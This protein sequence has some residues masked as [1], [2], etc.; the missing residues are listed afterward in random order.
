MAHNIR[1]LNDPTKQYMWINYCKEEEYDI[2]GTIETKL[3]PDK[4]K[5]IY[6]KD[7][8]YKAYWS[9]NITPKGGVGILISD[10]NATPNPKEDR[11]GKRN[12][13]I[14][15]SYLLKEMVKSNW[16]DVMRYFH[17]EEEKYTW[18]NNENASRIDQVWMESNSM[19]L[20]HTYIQQDAGL[21]TTS[22]H[23]I[24]G[25]K[26][27]NL[28]KNNNCGKNTISNHQRSI[29]NFKTTTSKEWENYQIN[30][31]EQLKNSQLSTD[32]LKITQD[33]KQKTNILES[34]WQR[35]S[36]C[37]W[38]AAKQTLPNKK[39]KSKKI[40]KE[41]QGKE[42]IIAYKQMQLIRKLIARV[43]RRDI[44]NNL[45]PQDINF[46]NYIKK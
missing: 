18:R 25:C 42:E 7:D 3:T 9:S 46:I 14:P 11:K 38:K 29:F 5:Y 37:I 33:N 12:S 36:E 28:Q 26:I 21:I 45:L 6:Q 4:D 32:T 43:K 39:T 17:D 10:F 13:S 27:Q 1:G 15:E 2:I 22:D 20:I 16:I 19:N 35:M 8:K 24:I 31:E 41:Q 34:Y 23:D 44:T 30:L 40:I